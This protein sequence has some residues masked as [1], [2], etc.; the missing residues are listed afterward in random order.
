M[1]NIITKVIDLIPGNVTP[2]T[3][4]D[5]SELGYDTFWKDFVCTHTP[6]IIRGGVKHWPAFN[7]WGEKGYLES[8]CKNETTDV[9]RGFNSI[10]QASTSRKKLVECLSE[11]HNLNCDDVYS[12]QSLI[13]PDE[14]EKDLETYSFLSKFFLKKTLWYPKKRLF[15]YKNTSTEWHYHP[16]DETITS[17]LVGE[18]RVSLFRLTQENWELYNPY[19]ST[20][21]HH[22]P[23]GKSFFPEESN[24][25]KFEGILEEGD[26]L[27]IPTFWWHGIDSINDK[28]GV[29]LAECFRTPVHR[30][31]SWS[32]PILK[33]LQ[34]EIPMLVSLHLQLLIAQSTLSRK[35]KGEKW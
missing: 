19:I 26:S 8:R 9:V 2:L 23:H 27:Y 4:I 18:K 22:M 5:A 21:V 13:V 32:E 31:G 16:A 6:V 20:N 11:L 10:P 24:L 25:V 15:I 30:F 28:V 14:W 17:Q 33:E 29:T 7:L 12:I 3:E 34:K 35:L 1:K